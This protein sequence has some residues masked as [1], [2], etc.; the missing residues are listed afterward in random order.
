MYEHD[1]RTRSI[2]ANFKG[3]FSLDRGSAIF[4]LIETKYKMIQKRG[5]KYNFKQ[6]HIITPVEIN[7]KRTLSIPMNV[8]IRN[9][10]PPQNVDIPQ[11]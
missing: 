2:R 9:H 3:I 6:I 5:K 7:V 8:N 11:A 1:R 10:Q 4:V